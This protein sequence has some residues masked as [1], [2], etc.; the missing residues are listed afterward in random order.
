MRGL[1]TS[2]L[3]LATV[4][5][6]AQN[7]RAQQTLSDPVISD[8]IVVTV[9]KREQ[10]IVD[11]PIAVSAFD[12]E[13]LDRIGVVKFDELALYVPGLEIQEQSPNNPG[14]VI[15]GVTSD[16]GEATVEPRVAVFQDGVSISRSRGSYVELFDMERVEVAK[17]PQATL[18]GRGAL[19]G[20]INLIQKKADTGS[21]GGEAGWSAGDY[22]YFRAII[23]LNAPIV[24]DMAAVRVA[25]TRRE[26][27]GFTTNLT[28]GSK[29]GGA[30][31]EAARVSL[32]VD[33]T[34]N[35]RFDLILNHQI[36]ENDGT[37]FKS[38]TFAP[39]GGTTSPFTPA[40]LNTFGGFEGGRPLGLERRVE[41]GTL[42][43][44]LDVSERLSLTSTTGYRY[45]E[46]FETFDPDGFQ[47]PVSI[48]GEDAKGMQWSQEL[49]LNFEA[50][51]RVTG[52]VGGSW[53]YEEG[54]QRVPLQFDERAVLALLTGQ[55]TRP[56]PQPFSV[57]S[58]SAFQQALL[59]ALGVPAIQR[60]VL[61]SLL[62]PA[63]REEFTNYGE[64][65]AVDIYGDVTV[66]VTDRLELSA[67][68]RW[69]QDDKT[70]GFLSTLPNGGS[71]LGALLAGV[72]PGAPVG[73]FTQPSAGLQSRSETYD[74]ITWRAVARYA[75]T[76]QTSLWASYARGR[77]P[78]VISPSAP[79]TPFG[80]TRFSFLPA[81]TADS[82]EV[83]AK[84]RFLDG[85]LDLDGSV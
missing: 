32:R 56:N 48:F 57:V 8:E 84:G 17:G 52:F 46:S 68:L 40:G 69:T 38:Q 29:L 30:D 25:Y 77:R 14:F 7:A 41:S 20:G 16:S 4:F 10:A 76:D 31:T 60:P 45:F 71:V 18:F 13:F 6:L 63:H 27:D 39:T 50:G 11:V 73:L 80:A 78:E 44:A 28:D 58:S 59:G 83:G 49:R 37:S 54:R 70:S 24:E 62:K 75:P 64:T 55:I 9:Q 36:D 2:A 22:D 42:I 82:V 5:G 3:A 74:D 19:I 61:A 65:T 72:A 1:W 43:G 85:A 53:F 34:R 12:G 23:A 33:P 66:A 79:A 51:S 67:G 21:F 26:R 47:Y 15:R 81:E 35:L